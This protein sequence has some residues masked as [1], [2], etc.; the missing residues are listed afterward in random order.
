VQVSKHDSLNENIVAHSARNAQRDSSNTRLA[1][2]RLRAPDRYC[3]WLHCVLHGMAVL[4][5]KCRSILERY[6]KSSFRKLAHFASRSNSTVLPGRAVIPRETRRGVGNES[7]DPKREIGRSNETPRGMNKVAQFLHL[8]ISVEGTFKLDTDAIEAVLNKAKDWYR[9]TP[10]CWI[11]YT[12][13]DADT[14]SERI[15]KLPSFETHA[16]FFIAELNL[17]NR[18][19][20]ASQDLWDWLGKTRT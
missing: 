5:G 12:A 3:N 16:T 13:K 18:S 7:S 2:R 19:G 8:G 14:W 17:D 1:S 20:W 15:R 11:I 10:N 4:A 6:R 9:Y